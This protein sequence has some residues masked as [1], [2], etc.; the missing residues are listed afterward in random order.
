MANVQGIMLLPVGLA[1]LGF[2]MGIFSA[3]FRWG[4]WRIFGGVSWL[5]A[6][7]IAEALLVQA[8]FIA[9]NFSRVGAFLI[10]G[11]MLFPIS[12]LM[13]VIER[14]IA[15]RRLKATQVASSAQM[16]VAALGLVIGLFVALSSILLP[17][18]TQ[19]LPPAASRATTTP[20]ATFS[21]IPTITPVMPPT[22]TPRPTLPSTATP[23]P[24]L[25]ITPSETDI[26]TLIQLPT[27]TPTLAM[28][29][30]PSSTSRIPTRTRTGLPPRLPTSE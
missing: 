2:A 16:P 12:I 27:T 13:I 6:V 30:T 21:P 8:I 23:L 15:A 19:P 11:L 9:I 1:V 18:I 28:T 10:G 5:L 26:P 20:I 7:I 3:R 25:T 24:S 29:L 22:N 17:V 14:I 4:G